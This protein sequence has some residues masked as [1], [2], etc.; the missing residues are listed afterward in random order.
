MPQCLLASSVFFRLHKTR[1]ALCQWQACLKN[2]SN[3]VIQAKEKSPQASSSLEQDVALQPLP[4]IWT[5]SLPNH[6]SPLTQIKFCYPSPLFLQS[7]AERS[8]RQKK[9]KGPNEPKG[10]DLTS[11]GNSDCS[12][13]NFSSTKTQPCTPDQ[14]QQCRFC[15]G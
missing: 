9:C 14:Q 12:S 15:S 2:K 10:C 13:W 3:L 8:Q 11:V 4:I 6:H 5:L 1:V 7:L